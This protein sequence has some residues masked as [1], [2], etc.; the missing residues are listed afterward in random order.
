MS[1]DWV[2]VLAQIA[3]FLVLLWLL[4]RFLY[5]P[6]LDGI[7]AREAS[8]S[9]RIADAEQAQRDAQVAKSDFV[10]QRAQLISDQDTLLEKALAATEEQRDGLLS[11]ARTKLL[12]EQKDWRK[13]LEHERQ[14]FN[15]RLQDTGAEALMRLTRKALHDLADETLE[16][17]IVRHV[18]QQ[19]APMAAELQQAAA[20]QLKAQVSTRDAL[21]AAT[22]TLLQSQVQQWLPDVVLS[23]ATDAQQSPG[24]VMQVGGAQVSWTTDSYMDELAQLLT[25]H[26]SSAAAVR[27]PAKDD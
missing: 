24:L 26:T 5:R 23:F 9:K 21:S 22:Q 10:K 16:D 20:G 1:I 8:I 11:D 7:D 4:K 18:S 6:I 3:N 27:L 13:H 2:T 12:Q 19:L 14:A 17:A 25:S 15:Q